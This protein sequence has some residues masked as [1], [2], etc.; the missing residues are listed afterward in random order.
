MVV[1][2]H[3]LR[4]TQVSHLNLL[5]PKLLLEGKSCGLFTHSPAGT[6]LFHLFSEYNKGF[7]LSLRLSPLFRD[8]DCL[9]SMH[10]ESGQSS[11]GLTQADGAVNNLIYLVSMKRRQAIHQAI[12]LIL[13]SPFLL[14]LFLDL[15]HWLL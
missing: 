5:P 15:N 10:L 8:E 13:K 14:Q 1:F 6:L 12:A 3:L 9:P 7:F 11:L 4:V 2:E